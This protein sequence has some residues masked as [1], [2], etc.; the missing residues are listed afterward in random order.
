MGY[1]HYECLPCKLIGAH[2]R[3]HPYAEGTFTGT[4]VDVGD[5][6]FANLRHKSREGTQMLLV[7][8]EP[9]FLFDIWWLKALV[10]DVQGTSKFAFAFAGVSLRLRRS[11]WVSYRQAGQAADLQCGNSCDAQQDS[12]SQQ[13]PP[14]A[15]RCLWPLRAAQPANGC[16]DSGRETRTAVKGF[17]EGVL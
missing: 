9:A 13:E 17:P 16:H 11:Q 10:A 1:Q 15:Q 2:S 8:N 7:P 5:L 14:Q 6:R 4:L 3:G 12:P